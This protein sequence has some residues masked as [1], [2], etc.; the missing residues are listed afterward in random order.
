MP[1]PERFGRYEVVRE[2]GRGGMAV[3]YLARDPRVGREVAIKA[4]SSD[5]AGEAEFRRRFDREAQALARLEHSAIVPLYD[6]GDEEGTPYLVFRY[7]EGGS[8]AKLIARSGSLA[9]EDVGAIARRV[10]AALDYAHGRGVIHRDIKPA[11][12]L[13]D[14]NGE[15][16]LG[17]FGISLAAERTSSLTSGAWIGSPAYM[18]PEQ[19]NGDP[20]TAAS[21][22]YSLGCTLFEAVTGSPPFSAE[23]PVA[24]L[25]KHVQEEASLASERRE[26]V[27]ESVDQALAKAL[28]KDPN[29]RIKSGGALAEALIGVASPGRPGVAVVPQSAQGHGSILPTIASAVDTGPLSGDVTRAVPEA[30]SPAQTVAEPE[31]ISPR[32]RRWRPRWMLAGLIG[33]GM[34]GAVAALVFAMM[35]GSDDDNRPANPTVGSTATPTRNMMPT[36]T[37]PPTVASP[38]P[39]IGGMAGTTVTVEPTQVPATAMPTPTAEVRSIEPDPSANASIALSVESGGVLV[40]WVLGHTGFRLEPHAWLEASFSLTNI[41]P[42]LTDGEW[43]FDEHDVSSDYYNNIGPFTDGGSHKTFI[44]VSCGDVWQMLAD[45]RLGAKS[46]SLGRTAKSAT[47]R[48]FVGLFTR[49]GPEWSGMDGASATL[50]TCSR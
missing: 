5:L 32:G 17:D 46:A 31:L 37:K 34:S 19:A 45:D 23:K 16:W 8:L 25:L 22:I 40:T 4:I 18:S 3:V 20:A 47:V 13:F 43:D 9:L 6:H 11:N 28:A 15:A 12:I 10:G 50:F 39:T 29:E 36:R 14:A 48:I 2:L 35:G 26:G 1:P 7:M 41:T 30:S 33:L 42:P 27:S 38:P 49:S 21:D 24:L 44:A